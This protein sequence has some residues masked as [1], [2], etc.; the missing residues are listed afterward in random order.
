MLKLI[1]EL[2]ATQSVILL[3][4]GH[5]ETIQFTCTFMPYQ[6]TLALVTVFSHLL[7]LT[8]KRGLCLCLTIAVPSWNKL[9]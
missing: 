2:V 6:H 1:M 7:V 9:H 5:R 8:L 4:S 3:E